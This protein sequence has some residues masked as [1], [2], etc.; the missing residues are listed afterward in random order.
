MK[1]SQFVKDEDI[2][3]DSFYPRQSASVTKELFENCFRIISFPITD[4]ELEA[5]WEDLN[6]NE[7]GIIE[8]THFYSKLSCWKD[9]LNKDNKEEIDNLNVDFFHVFSQYHS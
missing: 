9:N 5:I 3:K 8:L 1:F 6:G 7:T 4:K 2:M